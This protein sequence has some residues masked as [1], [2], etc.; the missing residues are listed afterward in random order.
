MRF[1]RSTGVL[2]AAL[3]LVAAVPAVAFASPVHHHDLVALD[4]VAAA[5]IDLGAPAVLPL[6]LPEA[7]PLVVVDHAGDRD[8]YCLDDALAARVD[9][10]L[11]LDL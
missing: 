7:H 11:D 1:P 3:G 10:V 9:A 8:L 4:A 5:R 2:V 6:C